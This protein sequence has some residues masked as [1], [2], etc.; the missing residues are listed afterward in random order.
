MKLIQIQDV[1]NKSNVAASKWAME[2]VVFSEAIIPW[3]TTTQV[4]GL[5]QNGR[6]RRSVKAIRKMFIRKISSNKFR[7]EQAVDAH[8]KIGIK[9]GVKD[10]TECV[11]QF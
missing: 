3:E 7:M 11:K 4:S 5:S 1:L 10:L 2:S 6:I 8:F 9:Y